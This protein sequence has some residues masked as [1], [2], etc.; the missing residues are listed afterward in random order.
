MGSGKTTCGSLIADILDYD[1]VDLDQE[2]EAVSGQTI[3]EIFR[4]AGESAFRALEEQATRMLAGRSLIVVA[5]GGGWMT[6]RRSKDPLPGSVRVWLTARP[7]TLLARAAGHPETRP[8]LD[9]EDPLGSI[10]QLLRER[11]SSYARAE[12]RVETDERTPDQVATEVVRQLKEGAWSQA[13]PT[14]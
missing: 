1:F 6:G 7:D 13:P 11:E 8:L 12:V 14:G 5:A 10:R 9:P 3:A 4:S 2:V